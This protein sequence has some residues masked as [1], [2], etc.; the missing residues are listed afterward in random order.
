MARR[1][2]GTITTYTLADGSV[3]Y[4]ARLMR[5]DAQTGKRIGESVT[6]ATRAEAETALARLVQ[7]KFEGST[8]DPSHLTVAELLERWLAEYATPRV[9]PTTLDSYRDSIR[10]HIA[11]TPLGRKRAQAVRVADISQFAA[12]LAASPHRRAAEMAL[13]RLK[14]AFKWGASVELLRRD[15]T[16][17]VTLPPAMTEPD[18]RYA[19]SHR[20]AR[21]LLAAAKDDSF[22]PIWR[23]YLAT[24]LRRGE[25]LGLR[26]QDLDLDRGLLSVRQQVVLAGRPKRPT[27]Q[28]PKSKSALRTIELDDDTIAALEAHRERIVTSGGKAQG[29]VFCTRHGGPLNPMNL[30]RS[31]AAICE[32][33]N[34]SGINIHSLRHTHVAHLILAGHPILEIS[35][36]LGHKHVSVTMDTYAHLIA[37]HQSGI[38][39]SVLTILG[40]ADSSPQLPESTSL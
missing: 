29:L 30:H 25:A 14:Q 1:R 6:T 10:L 2:A 7:A 4:L 20:E 35:R 15:V 11:N 18:E 37:G 36:R 8:V 3:R 28:S 31:F 19:L 16:A 26:W 38:T 40:G 24:G 39:N 33:A 12:Q 5:V 22:W 13:L 17:G 9:K 34:I 21:A 32:R 23:V 27:I